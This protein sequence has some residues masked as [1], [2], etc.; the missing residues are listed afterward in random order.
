MLF[1]AFQVSRSNRKNIAERHWTPRKSQWGKKKSEVAPQDEV[2]LFK[3]LF[4]ARQVMYFNLY[5][6]PDSVLGEQ[7]SDKLPIKLKSIPIH[8][9]FPR[10]H[11]ALSN[12]LSA[13]TES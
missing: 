11:P 3:S 5:I 6:P 12:A 10:H 4:P 7:P 8:L 1:L 9:G 2:K 13:A